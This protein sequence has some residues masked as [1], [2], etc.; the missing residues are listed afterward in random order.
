MNQKE[1]RILDRRLTSERLSLLPVEKT[2]VEPLHRLWTVEQVRRFLW[3]GKVIPLQQT[4]EIVEKSRELFDQYGFG[5][6]GIRELNSDALVGFVGLWHF[7]QP[8]SLEL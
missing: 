2:D 8:P 5:I 6:W 4:R 1:N 3:D 7:H